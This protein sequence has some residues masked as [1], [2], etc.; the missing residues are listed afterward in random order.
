MGQIH[1]CTADECA[2]YVGTH[3][4]TC[5]LTGLYHGHT[6]G[7][8]GYIPQ[9]KRTWR[10]KR[11]DSAAIPEQD[12]QNGYGFAAPP[13]LVVEYRAS[14]QK[15]LSGAKAKNAPEEAV[16]VLAAAVGRQV[17]AADME[18][19]D[20]FNIL[21]H[22]D[23]DRKRIAP[24]PLPELEAKP[25]TAEK[26]GRRGKRRK[27]N[28]ELLNI[29]S[30]RERLCAIAEDIVETLLFSDTRRQFNNKKRSLSQ[31]QCAQAMD[32]YYDA[33]KAS[34]PIA[35]ELMEIMARH[36]QN[37]HYLAILPRDNSVIQY[38]VRVALETWR[39]VV[40]SPWAADNPGASFEHHAM[41]ILYVLRDGLVI[42]NFPVIQRDEF[43]R[44]LPN[45]NDLP[46]FGV[47]FS[48]SV[49]TAGLKHIRSAYLSAAAAKGMT[50]DALT[51][52][53]EAPVIRETK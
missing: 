1:V 32:R 22:R 47:R 40:N 26:S 19:F 35:I 50:V 23:A 41:S 2:Q 46:C 6:R 14:V 11:G 8:T 51:L 3:E 49:V 38:Y 27:L 42:E 12:G 16:P 17:Q 36:E 34:F 15:S 7:D 25:V 28:K 20:P 48:P 31:M 9:E 5:P 52:R 21:E 44:H 45:R 33:C 39:V 13:P 18:T 4:G 37:T 53:V 10:M 43:M 24:L 29:E 30:E